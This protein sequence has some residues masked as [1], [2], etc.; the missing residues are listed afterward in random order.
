MEAYQ[1]MDGGCDEFDPVRFVIDGSCVDT[2]RRVQLVAEPIQ[3]F[4]HQS[5]IGRTEVLSRYE[6]RIAQHAHLIHE[7]CW[8]C[9]EIASPQQAEKSEGQQQPA[10]LVQDSISGNVYE[11]W[12]GN[13]ICMISAW[14]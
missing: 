1:E 10:P 8:V 7:I 6:A 12:L 3:D 14:F 2:V 5:E 9:C 13:Y 4:G 11:F